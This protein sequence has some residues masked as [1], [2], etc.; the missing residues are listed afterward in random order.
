M[1]G[2]G[3]LFQGVRLIALR[4]DTRLLPLVSWWQ[5]EIHTVLSDKLQAVVLGGSTV[6]GDFQPGW[7]DVDVC[8]VLRTPITEAEGAV[9]GQVH[10]AMRAHFI[11]GGQDGWRSGQAIEGAYI[12]GEM[13]Q[14]GH[15]G[16]CYVAGGSTR[17]WGVKDPISPFDRL[18]YAQHG[19]W[20]FGEEV[21]I[22]LPDGKALRAQSIRD[23]Q[24]FINPPAGCLES[25]IWL[26]GIMHW[27]SRTLVFWR[28]GE[29][30]SKTAALEREVAAG[31]PLASAFI[32]P[33]A[34]RREG[35]A[36]CR[37][38]VDDLRY[39]YQANLDTAVQSL[40]EVGLL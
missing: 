4:G 29:L 25:A 5:T 1:P 7:S 15:A 3:F 11:D 31:R 21:P 35:S 13:L 32:L 20:L 37:Q 33:L 34:L 10:D 27:L 19:C 24:E 40:V 22:A 39:N 30:V 12:T 9:I 36:A 26:A 28:D 16:T 18:I 38:H 8:V 6:L 2:R 17:W 14:Y 23:S